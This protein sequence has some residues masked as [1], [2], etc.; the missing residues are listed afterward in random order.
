[1]LMKIKSTMI[2]AA[3]LLGFGSLAARAESVTFDVSY[4]DAD[5]SSFIKEKPFVSEISRNLD[6]SVNFSSFFNNDYPVTVK[7][8]DIKVGE[9]AEIEFVG[10]Y[11]K[12][13][14][15]YLHLATDEG[16]YARCYSYATD[17]EGTETT[18]KYPYFYTDPGY[19]FISRESE[20]EYYLNICMTGEELLDGGEPPYYYLTTTFTMPAI[21]EAMTVYVCDSRYNEVAKSFQTP[22]VMNEDGSF[23]MTDFFNSGYPISFTFDIPEG[24]NSTPITITSKCEIDDDLT[25]LKTPFKGSDIAF[26]IY[27]SDGDKKTTYWYPSTYHD[28]NSVSRFQDDEI[29]NYG[30][31]YYGVI[32]LCGVGSDGKW[33][34]LYYLLFY[35]NLPNGETP[36]EPQE[37]VGE[38]LTVYVDDYSGYDIAKSFDTNFSYN[39]DGSYTM[40]DFFNSGKPVSFT[41]ETPERGEKAEI[42]FTSD[43]E[44]DG[45]EIYF[46]DAKGNYLTCYAYDLEGPGKTELGWPYAYEGY[47]YVWRYSEEEQA[48]YGCEYYACIPVSGYDNSINAWSSIWY[49]LEFYFTTP[50][51][52]GVQ[53]IENTDAPVEFYNLNGMR[54]DNPANGIFIRK[55][56]NQIKKVV[57]R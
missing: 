17:A 22:F 16:K 53:A 15:G 41:F 2:G 37:P 25:E 31:E 1:M 30:Y 33:S 55:Q 19:N 57:I 49:Y 24:D 5:A 36:E 14:K 4:W 20:N 9:E 47:S 45:K 46:L 35:F 34:D 13:R 32:T 40:S 54:V 7:F 12:E 10:N 11:V 8:N 6:G 3:L 26:Y 52:S 50:T 48:A 51:T 27:S 21:P 38:K 44:L 39:E 18:I 28:S 29:A 43:T 23:T 56:G 42:K